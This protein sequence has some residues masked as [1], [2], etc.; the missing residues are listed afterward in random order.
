MELDGSNRVGFN[1]LLKDTRWSVQQVKGQSHQAKPS[2]MKSEVSI[3]FKEHLHSTIKSE[4]TE[5]LGELRARPNEIKA[6]SSR[7]T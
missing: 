5:V 3:I 6:R 2:T 1:V 7:P 4:D